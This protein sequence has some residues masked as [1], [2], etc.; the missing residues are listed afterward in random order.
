MPNLSPSILFL[1]YNYGTLVEYPPPAYDIF[2]LLRL[3]S[4]VSRVCEVPIQDELKNG[5]DK[6]SMAVQTSHSC[7]YCYQYDGMLEHDATSAFLFLSGLHD[8]CSFLS[9]SDRVSYG[10]VL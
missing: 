3:C 2:K 1:F 7:C 6:L 5:V 8:R 9:L 10:F 4:Q